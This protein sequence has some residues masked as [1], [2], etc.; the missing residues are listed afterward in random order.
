VYRSPGLSPE[1]IAPVADA[2][3]AMGLPVGGE[4]DLFARALLDL[5]TVEVPVAETETEAETGRKR[6]RHPKSLPSLKR[7]A[8]CRSKR[9]HPPRQPKQSNPNRRHKPSRSS[10]RTSLS[11]RSPSRSRLQ[12]PRPCRAIRRSAWPCLRLR[13]RR[14]SLC[15]PTQR[16]KR[17]RQPPKQRPKSRRTTRPP[18]PPHRTRPPPHRTPRC[19][20]RRSGT[21]GVGCP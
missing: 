2:A 1:T 18:N 11:K 10:S 12:W 15:L 7:K 21:A 14:P 16:P 3:R 5:Q 4:L 8:N 9:L 19:G 20:C 13:K 6:K 17:L